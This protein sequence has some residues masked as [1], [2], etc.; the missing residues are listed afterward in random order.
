MTDQELK[1]AGQIGGLEAVLKV[2]LSMQLASGVNSSADLARVRREADG[3]RDHL[4]NHIASMEAGAIRQGIDQ[5][6][7]EIMLKEMK[8]TVTRCLDQTG[9]QLDAVS[10][11]VLSVTDTPS[12]A[13]N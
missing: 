12:A 7:V 11:L 8:D 4:L 1:F 5:Q 2:L 10:K 6:V 9:A 3:L 13:A